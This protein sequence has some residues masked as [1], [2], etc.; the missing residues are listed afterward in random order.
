MKRFNCIFPGLYNYILT[1][2]VGMIPYILSENG[3]QATI[4]TYDNDDYTYMDEIL[5]SDNLKLDYLEGDNEVSDVTRYIRV[6]AKSID[7]IEFYHLRYDKLPR[8]IFTYKIR[9]PRGKI[10]L[11]L[12]ANNDIIDFLVRRKGLMP[13]VRRL[14]M[15][16]LFRFISVVSIETRRN[17]DVLRR[18]NLIDTDKLLYLPNGVLKT[19]VPVDNKEKI[20]LQV[21]YIQKDNK[22]TDMLLEAI[23]DIS[24]DDWKLVLVG[25]VTEDMKDYLDNYFKENPELVDKVV[26]KGYIAD[27]QVLSQEYARSSI[28]VCTSLKESFGISTLEAA[29]HGNYIIS[30]DVGGSRDIIDSTGYGKIIGNSQ[31]CLKQCLEE[32]MNNWD[33]YRKD[34]VEV[35]KIV[36]DSYSWDV[37]CKKLEKY[38]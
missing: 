10:H 31:D 28:Y 18:S 37:L 1:K 35:Q 7:V 22:R 20:I 11:K 15:R 36:Y 12:D 6:N 29:Y 2:D 5:K 21:G 4:T 30:T 27:K 19:D 24:L 16:V 13:A 32:S 34:P 33:E 25:K 9:N 3:Y 38:F 23:R 26:L 8:Y 14:L 17:Y